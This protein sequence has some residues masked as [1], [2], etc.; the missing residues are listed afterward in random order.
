MSK[1]QRLITNINA[2]EIALKGGTISDEERKVLTNYSGFGEFKCILLDPQRPE[3]FSNSEKHLIPHVERLHEILNQ[4]SQDK[5][6]YRLYL[7]SLKRSVLTSFYTPQALVNVINESFQAN[8]LNFKNMLDPSSGTGIFLDI[9]ADKHTAIEKEII[10]GRIL[11]AL[12]DGK[13]VRI[14]GFEDIPRSCENSFDLVC[15]N[16]PFGDFKVFDPVLLKSKNAERLQSCN[17]IHKYF[18]EKGLDVLKEGG[19]MAF[20]TSTGV[21]DAKSNQQFREHLLKRSHL[22]SAVR[23]PE[24]TFTGTKV[25]SD[26]IILQKN[27][28]RTKR[29]SDSEKLFTTNSDVEGISINS[30]YNNFANVVKTGYQVDTDLYGKPG[31]RFIHENGIEGISADLKRVLDADIAKNINAFII[32]KEERVEI[33]GKP[34]Q[35]TLFDDLNSF[36]SESQNITKV[37]ESKPATFEFENTVYDKENSFQISKSGDVGIVTEGKKAAILDLPKNEQ[38]LIKDFINLRDAYFKLKD[39]E[40]EHRTESTENRRQLNEAYDIFQSRHSHLF[41]HVEVFRKDPSYIELRGLEKV[42]DDQILKA[43][44]FFEPVSFSLAKEN[45]TVQEALSVSLNRLNEVDLDLI[46]RLSS[47]H[48]DKVL[49]ELEGLI[50]FNS[51]NNSFEPA[52][53]YLSGNVVEKLNHAVKVY[54]SSGGNDLY[55]LNS[56]KAL[57]NILPEK[58]PFEDIGI[59]LGERWIP[60]QYYNTFANEVFKAENMIVKYNRDLDEFGVSARSSYYAS[61]LYGVQTANRHYSPSDVL[62]F[63]LLD[64]MPGMTIK[65]KSGDGYVTRP[66]SE[67]IKKMNTAMTLL[68]NEFKIWLNNLDD[69][70]KTYLKDLYNSKFNCYVKPSY[71]GHFQTFPG[72]DRENLGITDLYPTQKNAI[73]LLKNQGGG[74]IDH[75][76]GSGKTLIMCVAAYEMKRL[77]LANKPCIIGL[78]ANIGQIA[79]TFKKAYPEAKVLFATEKE[80]DKKNREQLF[81]K[82]QNNNWDCIILSHEQFKKIPQSAGIQKQI[83]SEE[84]HKIEE[85]LDASKEEGASYKHLQ[86]GLIKRQQDL[87]AKLQKVMFTLDENKD[88]V[89]D[90]K[91]MGIDHLFV[92]ESHKFKNLTFATRHTR[93]AGLGNPAGSDRSMNMLFALRTIQEKTAKDL[94][95][96]FLSGTVIS[97]SLTELYSIFNYLRP[98]ALIEQGIFSFDAWASIYALKSKDFEFNVTNDIVL[99][100]RF[101]QFVK[102]P[103]LSMF[104]SQITDFKTA[105]DVGVVRPEKN[106]ILLSLEQ[107]PQQIDMFKRLKEFAKT[108]DGEKIF[109]APLSDSEDKAKMLIATNTS[110]K[111]SLDMR[112]IDNN[113]FID[114]DRSKTNI[115]VNKIME[116]YEKYNHVKGTQFVFSDL[117]TYK[118]PHDFSIYGDV[119]EKLVQ[120]GIPPE[121]IQFIQNHNT[122]NKKDAL[123]KKMNSGEVR[124]LFGS[125]EMLGTGVNAQQRAIAIHHYNI[126]WTPKDMEQRNGRAV[127]QGNEIAAK[128]AGNKVDVLIYATK[129]TLDTY[130]FTLLKNKAAFIFQIKS[131]NISVRQIDEGALD[132]HSGM[133]YSEYIAVLSGNTDLLEK[134]K[135]EKVVAQYKSE[136]ATYIKQIRDKEY[137]IKDL[138]LEKEKNSNFI[139][140]FSEDLQKFNSLPK[141]NA[142]IIGKMELNG[143]SYTNK[144][145]FGEAIISLLAK[146]NTNTVSYQKVGTFGGFNLVMKAEINRSENEH[147]KYTNKLYVEGNL[148]YSFNF[149]NVANNPKLAGEYP[150]NALNRIPGL[151]S[152]Y[153]EKNER[154]QDKL[155]DLSNLEFKF[156]NKDKYET[157]TKQLNEIN[158]RLQKIIV[159]EDQVQSVQESQKYKSI[160]H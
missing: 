100:E 1:Q 118:S 154:I 107:T 68:Q 29:L 61:E 132:E 140:L 137:K 14:G 102:V 110:R 150:V 54:E 101:R 156:I 31:L 105:K 13:E 46:C 25:Q 71:N 152:Q 20:I 87:E 153:S 121:Q 143:V 56:I 33:K 18:F 16:I 58:I 28:T 59:S 129:N 62:R 70:H 15:S 88:N 49:N 84:L 98:N 22:V 23:L 55:L 135:L 136:E 7:D 111:A 21:M 124:V 108:G 149:G 75:E 42:Q 99:K 94:G 142:I 57:N 37:E 93:V 90:F 9:K 47:S 43:D 19:V 80:F 51:I 4:Y 117:G 112:L 151:I 83:I 159:K 130:N 160:T 52:D 103:E 122:T 126:P 113:R 120:R 30:L 133:N 2:I 146:E 144:D 158:D 109:R 69:K 91:T 26:L 104:Y 60:T 8:N 35:L 64:V 63:A 3:T 24:N 67:G 96:T 77:G 41:D 12:H 27:S 97:N 148:K 78:K 147:I 157:A 53:R 38:E 79:D 85:A 32:N 86:K 17:A 34:M 74:I 125:T 66:D 139:R 106:E 141:D 155:S 128:Y 82:I 10:T 50:F 115:L 65:V 72:L 76:V 11:K 95:A 81:S 39:F 145:K 45:Y 6:E 119:K 40:S 44:I 92:D 116:Y 89:I 127:R 138:S 36:I 131:N 123:F 114:E 134:A 48:E 5:S 73:L